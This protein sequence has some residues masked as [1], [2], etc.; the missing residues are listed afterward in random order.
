VQ[1]ALTRLSPEKADSPLGGRHGS[2][3][4]RLAT[5]GPSRLPQ[6]F[7]INTPLANGGNAG[8]KKFSFRVVPRS[9][10]SPRSRVLAHLSQLPQLRQKVRICHG[11]NAI[12]L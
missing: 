4:A 12:D 3:S 11:R 8:N 7:L 6:F 1:A 5:F 10:C 9:K 2:V